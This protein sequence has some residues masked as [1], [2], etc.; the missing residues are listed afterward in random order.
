MNGTTSSY[1]IAL[2]SNVFGS[3]DI[4]GNYNIG[5]GA[6]ISGATRLGYYNTFIGSSTG[7]TVTSINR[8]TALG[9]NAKCEFSSQ[10][11]IGCS[12]E[13]VSI[14]GQMQN[15]VYTMAATTAT[16]GGTTAG[17]ATFP[18]YVFYTNT[19]AGTLTMGVPTNTTSSSITEVHIRRGFGTAASG[20]LTIAPRG[21][22]ISTT[23]ASSSNTSYVLTGTTATYARYI[24]YAAKW[25]RMN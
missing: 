11:V 17:S 5:V 24:Y 16:I 25:Y 2:G 21:T 13:Y 4:S 22:V 18:N 9:V 1:N 10:I 14:P 8:S 20:A 6:N 23:G 3:G 7:T 12:S 19:A 15:G